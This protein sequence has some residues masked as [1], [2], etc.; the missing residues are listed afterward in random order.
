M[1]NI[2]KV[3]GFDTVISR[4]TTLNGI[5]RL[6]ICGGET[7]VIDGSVFGTEI[8][9][10]GLPD[11]D[12]S[13]RLMVGGLIKVKEITVS[14]VVITGEVTCDV[15]RVENTLAIKA[16]ATLQAKK[17]LFR[18]LSVEDGAII[19]AALKHLD[20]VSEGEVT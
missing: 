10:A 15:L 18:H 1:K 3:R 17:V 7:C 14:N 8:V 19:D 11:F 13:T 9:E 5:E 12:I 16:G 2:F 4:G 20:H 6:Q